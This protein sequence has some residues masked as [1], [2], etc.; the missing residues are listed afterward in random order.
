MGKTCSSIVVTLLALLAAGRVAFG[1]EVNTAVEAERA[2]DACLERRDY[3]SAIENFTKAIRL[4]PKNARA[5]CGSGTAYEHKGD[6]DSAIADYTEAIRLDP[7]L[8]SAHYGRGTAYA[9]KGDYDKAIADFAEAVRLAE[10][11]RSVFQ[12]GQCL[13]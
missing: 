8:A 9:H 13:R 12:P 10:E 4:D 6:H 5:Y 11:C 7:K 2:G 3:S 1:T